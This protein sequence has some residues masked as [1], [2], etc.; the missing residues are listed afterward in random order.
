M[1]RES[2]MRNSACMILPSGPTA[3][4]TSSAPSA[5]LYQSIACAAL[6]RVS[7]G[8]TVW[9][10]S[11]TAFFAF[12]ISTSFITIHEPTIL[13]P[14][15]HAAQ[16]QGEPRDLDSESFEM[17]AAPKVGTTGECGDVKVPQLC[18]S[19]EP[20]LTPA[21]RTEGFAIIVR[22]RSRRGAPQSP[23]ACRS[24]HK[25]DDIAWKTSA[26]TELS[27]TRLRSW[28]AVEASGA[29]ALVDW[30]RTPL[31]P[32]DGWPAQPAR[33]PSARCLHSR[34]PMF[35]WWGPELI[36]FYN[37]AYLPSFGEGKHPAAMGQRG[38]DCWQEIWPIIW[39]QIDDVMRRGAG[40]L[41]RGPPRAHLPQRPASKRS[42]GPTATRRSSTTM[43]AIGGTLVV[44]TETTSRVVVFA[45]K[46]IVSARSR[47]IRSRRPARM[48][49][50]ST[51]A[52]R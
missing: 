44:C 50:S 34:H 6:S 33:P 2:P 28:P 16:G 51:S 37:D 47:E 10:P 15:A 39:P 45:A 38:R 27:K 41:E 18:L 40:Q 26:W 30:A 14:R 49:H 42:T 20:R 52:F 36:Q 9:C 12:A 25:V 4:D 32:I 35:L 29:D 19:P 43:A 17:D 24:R 22:T 1:M 3:R 21:S 13:L 48:W 23:I 46:P 7:C 31:G 5:F 11:G 8:V